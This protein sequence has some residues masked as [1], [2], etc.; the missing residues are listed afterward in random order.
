MPLDKIIHGKIQ[1]ALDDFSQ[2]HPSKDD[3]KKMFK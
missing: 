3:Y 2:I 1:P